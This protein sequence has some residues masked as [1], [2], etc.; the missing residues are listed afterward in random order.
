MQHLY[1]INM[2]LIILFYVD[3]HSFLPYKSLI[4]Q[5]ELIIENLSPIWSTDIPFNGYENPHLIPSY[6]DYRDLIRF[7]NEGDIYVLYNIFGSRVIEGYVVYKIDHE[8]GFLEWEYLR[9]SK[10]FKYRKISTS[11]YGWRYNR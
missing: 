11:S 8:T 6:K 5:S 4:G 10:K 9:Q 2:H 1:A 3:I 7:D